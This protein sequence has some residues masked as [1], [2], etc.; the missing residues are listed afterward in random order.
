MSV[1]IR[2]SRIGSKKE[3]RYRVVAK[4]TRS[5]RDGKALEILGYY[6][7]LASEALQVKIDM[8]KYTEWVKKGAVPSRTVSSLVRRQS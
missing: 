7:P 3:A 4:N 6:H 8:G 5:P 1:T 2:L